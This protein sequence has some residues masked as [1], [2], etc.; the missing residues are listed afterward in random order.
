MA[1][2]QERNL[3][4][5]AA[6]RL[7]QRLQRHFEAT[8]FHAELLHCLRHGL[9][10]AGRRVSPGL[11]Q[12]PGL[13]HV[14]LLRRLLV[15][16]QRLQIAG[17]IERDQLGFPAVQ[18]RWQVRGSALVAPRQRHPQAHALVQFGQALRVGIGPAQVGVQRMNGIGR[19]G[20][21]GTQHFAERRELGL[22]VLRV[23]QQR[24]SPGQRGQGAGIV[25]FQ[26]QQGAFGSFDQRLR[27]RSARVIGRQFF[28]FVRA[29]CQ[30]GHLRDLP[31]KPL[32]LALQ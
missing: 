27:I 1:A 10:Q 22:D 19:L 11:A 26:R 29:G 4:Q 30:L 24:R 12:C 3:L 9:G 18:Q 21:A 16:L 15:V 20:Q 23:L 32:A 8:T 2:D 6:G 5:S 17:G 28:P 25:V 13:C 7:R 14:A 31:L